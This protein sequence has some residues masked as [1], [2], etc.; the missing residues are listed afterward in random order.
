[1]TSSRISVDNTSFHALFHAFQSWHHNMQNIQSAAKLKFPLS[2]SEEI[3]KKRSSIFYFT[4]WYSMKI[5]FLHQSHVF[6]YFIFVFKYCDE[7]D[8]YMWILNKT[9]GK[10]LIR[11]YFSISL[12]KSSYIHR[13]N[14]SIV[15][16]YIVCIVCRGSLLR[17]SNILNTWWLYECWL[18]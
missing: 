3:A 10:L 14:Y 2:L 4:K 18:N 1:M 5:S 9:I 7:L 17:V 6:A 8:H 16:Q 11:L 15:N 12:K 13:S